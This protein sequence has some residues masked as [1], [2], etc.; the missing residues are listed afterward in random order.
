MTGL[1]EARASTIAISLDGRKQLAGDHF[2]GY[3]VGLTIRCGN[4]IRGYGGHVFFLVGSDNRQ[5]AAL[6][7]CNRQQMAAKPVPP[8]QHSSTA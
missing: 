4:R 6:A 8:G 7:H 3:G 5:F 1:I 2:A